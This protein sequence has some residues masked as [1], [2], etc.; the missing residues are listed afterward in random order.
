MRRRGG[1]GE[2]MVGAARGGN[3]RHP[4]THVT[5]EHVVERCRLA[6]ACGEGDG[7][8]D[9]R[10][11]RRGERL[12]PH[13][14]RASSRRVS[15]ARKSRLDDRPGGCEAPHS[16]CL[17]GTLQH[18][19]IAQRVRDS[20]LDGGRHGRR[21]KEAGLHRGEELRRSSAS[22]ARRKDECA[23]SHLGGGQQSRRQ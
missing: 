19:V 22:Q 18:H 9:A 3:C 10:R 13:R 15:S 2:V 8:P 12:P 21:R 14:V 20:K 6:R 5:K 7:L 16:G 11:G 1:R 17:R 23:R 4:P